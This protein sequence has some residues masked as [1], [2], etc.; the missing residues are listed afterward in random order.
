VF[1]C[2]DEKKANKKYF[3]E[4]G[5]YFDDPANQRAFFEYLKSIDIS[6]VDW[7]NDRPI[8]E[9]YNDIKFANT[10]IQVKFFKWIV[11][12]ED[13]DYICK[14]SGE[15]I[16]DA[17]NIFIKKGNYKNI[18]MNATSF[19]RLIKPY[20]KPK[21]EDVDIS[22]AFITKSMSNGRVVYK[23]AVKDVRDWLIANKHIE[24]CKII[25]NDDD[26]Y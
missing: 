1:Q 21:G 18:D 24:D 25:D 23:M 11:E 4:L 12:N 7:I 20:I 13:I 22:K 10:P 5:A 3:N 8:T 6:N 16:F 15:S 2:S 19:G 26:E 9:L 14:Y 17:F